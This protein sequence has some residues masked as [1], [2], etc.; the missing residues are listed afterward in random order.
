MGKQKD[1]DCDSAAAHAIWGVVIIFVTILLIF[2]AAFTSKTK[3]EASMN[4]INF[5]NNGTIQEAG[6]SG[7]NCSVNFNIEVPAFILVEVIRS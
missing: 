6:L 5:V 4:C 3:V 2:S 1:C 7:E